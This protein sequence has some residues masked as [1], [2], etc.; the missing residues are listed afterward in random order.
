MEYYFFVTIV[1]G[2]CCVCPKYVWGRGVQML[3]FMVCLSSSP[4][5]P[6]R[7]WPSFRRVSELLTPS[8]TSLHYLCTIPRIP[9]SLFPHPPQPPIPP[10]NGTVRYFILTDNVT[11]ATVTNL[12]L[13][14]PHLLS[15]LQQWRG[16]Q[17]SAG[18]PD[19]PGWEREGERRQPGWLRRGWRRP[20]QWR[21]LLHRPV[22]REEGQGGD[23][24]QRELWG[25]I[26]GQCHLLAS[27]A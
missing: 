21:W 20:V 1:E 3:Y 2:I 7:P 5:R 12:W 15:V 14:L 26:P 16:Q 23:R 27:I 10:T 22:H 19:F 8:R 17:A 24:R 18:Q 11:A 4:H 25:H 6:E 9:L 13:L